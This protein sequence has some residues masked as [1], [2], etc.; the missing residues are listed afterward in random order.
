MLNMMIIGNLGADAEIKTVNGKQYLSFRVAHSEKFTKQDGTEIEETTWVSCITSSFLKV[1]EYL[2]K[3]QKVFVQ[4][5]GK[6]KA[7]FRPQQRD[8]I[9]GI[10]INVRTLELCSPKAKEEMPTALFDNEGISHKVDV[11]PF[12]E[13]LVSTGGVLVDSQLQNWTVRNDGIAFRV[14]EVK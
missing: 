7:V 3:G 10:N 14:E 13:D 5:E 4:G 8:Y 12:V 6:V 9:A 11:V 2:K 1:A